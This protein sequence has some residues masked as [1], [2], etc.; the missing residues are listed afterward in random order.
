MK[1]EQKVR[2]LGPRENVALDSSSSANE[3][4]LNAWSSPDQR[5]GDG[6]ARI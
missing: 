5:P 3:E 1:V 6:D 4:R 2:K